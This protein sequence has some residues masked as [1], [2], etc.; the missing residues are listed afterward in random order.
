VQHVIDVKV[1]LGIVISLRVARDGDR[2]AVECGSATML[3]SGEQLSKS[4]CPSAPPMATHTSA[5]S[6]RMPQGHTPRPIGGVGAIPPA[7]GPRLF[8]NPS[9]GGVLC[10]RARVNGGGARLDGTKTAT[11]WGQFYDVTPGFGR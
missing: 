8:P 1:E 5:M 2:P 3:A 10:L 9:G 11:M 6:N 7:A 4:W